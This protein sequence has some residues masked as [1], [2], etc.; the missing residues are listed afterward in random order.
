[1]VP[2]RMALLVVK[3]PHGEQPLAQ[4]SPASTLAPTPTPCQDPVDIPTNQLLKGCGPPGLTP[5][6]EQMLFFMA[7]G[8]QSSVVKYDDHHLCVQGYCFS[9][10]T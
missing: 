10:H 5:A 4:S 6:Q 3:T 7:D 8:G 1:M 2:T 9:V